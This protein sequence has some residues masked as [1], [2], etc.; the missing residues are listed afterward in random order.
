MNPSNRVFGS[1]FISLFLF[2]QQ[3]AP[4]QPGPTDSLCESSANI[5]VAENCQQGT[6]D[7]HIENLQGDIEG[8]ASSTSRVPGEAIDFYVNTDADTFDLKIYRSGYYGGTGGRLAYSAENIPGS[9]QP[10]CDLDRNLGL[11]NCG[12]W[13]KSYSLTI[14]DDWISGV[15]IAKLIRPDTGGENYVLFVVREKEPK[16]DIVVQLS[17]TTY[18]AY[19]FYGNKSLYSSLS[20]DYCPTVSEAPRAVAV[21][22]DRPNSLGVYFQ[23]TYFWSDY[24]MI[25]WLEAQ[26]YSVGYITNID[27]HHYG[28]PGNDNEL[29]THQIFLSLGH[30]EYWSQEMRSAITEARDHGVH[31]GFFSSN[32]S[33]WRIRLETNS[34]TD[35]SDRTEIT[36]K[37]T[38]GGPADP[39]GHP[40][41]TW[42]DPHGVNDPENSLIGI[43][44]VGDNDIHYFPVQ[45]TAEQAKDRLYRNT[46]LQSMPPHSYARVGKHLIGW[47]WDAMVNNGLTPASLQIVAESPTIGS[48]LADAGRKYNYGATSANVTR[49][50]TS[51]GAI[52]FA[53]G[54]NHWS[55]GLAIYEPNPIIQQ[56]TYNLFSDMGVQPASP[57]PALVLDSNEETD[58]MGTS[59]TS[60][61]QSSRDPSM[62]SAIENFMQIWAVP[63]FALAAE[64][65]PVYLLYEND[66]LEIPQVSNIQVEPA[67][68][69]VTISWDTSLPTSSQLWVKSQSGSVDWGVTT[70][71][72]GMKPIV[73]E[74]L[75]ETLVNQHELTVFGLLPNS[76]YF[77]HVAGMAQ[78]GTSVVSEEAG[79]TTPSGGSIDIQ[80]KRYLRPFYREVRCGWNT[81]K[82]PIIVAGGLA[83]FALGMLIRYRRYFKA[84]LRRYGSVPKR[85]VDTSGEARN[86]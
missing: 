50:V 23:N 52:V 75:Q 45:V 84:P 74:A 24:P 69:S 63:D 15:Y 79:F 71:A 80:A 22:F 18:Q 70:E 41:T 48:L 7:W 31:L 32:I 83:I 39:S 76:K 16:S 82:F 49:Y 9:V 33:Y 17:V 73:A 8:F 34:L 28:T 13:L 20:F 64:S 56:I 10:E 11:V 59:T 46:P 67:P 38:E 26:G 14:P 81:N 62:V 1:F 36:Y 12:N 78:N 30:D 47:E 35:M 51:S 27:T 61:D 40:T 37:T 4:V 86:T 57:E 72:V 55:W 19:N 42:R 66:S 54:T 43:Q 25:Y 5:I 3:P 77:F 21:S 44:Y 85:K 58:E 68:E 53:V 2:M 65:D 29:L 60:Q 6:S